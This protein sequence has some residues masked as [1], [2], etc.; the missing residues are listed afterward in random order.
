MGFIR[1]QEERLAQRLLTWHYENNQIPLP[2][3]AAL[4]VRAGR[5]VDEAHRIASRRGQ[6]LLE[7]LNDLIQDVKRDD[8]QEPSRGG[9]GR[10]PGD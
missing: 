10:P 8:S 5:L 9:S 7:I 6:N 3:Q 1:R 2:S 4:R